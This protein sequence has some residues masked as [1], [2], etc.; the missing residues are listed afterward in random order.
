LR[1]QFY[2]ESKRKCQYIGAFGLILA[3]YI[4]QGQKDL[5]PRHAV[6]EVSVLIA[7]IG[8]NIAFNEISELKF[9]TYLL[10]I[11]IYYLSL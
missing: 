3:F 1:C 8:L 10:P 2:S 7:Y 6:L 5:N 4:W 11:T 9:I